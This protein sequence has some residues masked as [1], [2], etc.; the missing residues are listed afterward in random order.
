VLLKMVTLD[1]ARALGLQE[2]IGSLAAGKLADLVAFPCA[3]DTIDSRAAV[4]E[5]A[6][7][8]VGVW[9][10]GQRVV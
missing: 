7:A 6:P 1:A 3:V 8:P 9:V 10:A 4:L 2:Q 5:R